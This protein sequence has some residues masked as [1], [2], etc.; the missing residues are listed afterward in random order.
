MFDLSSAGTCKTAM[1][2]HKDR[3]KKIPMFKLLSERMNPTLIPNLLPSD[4]IPEKCRNQI[5]N[6]IRMY[7]YPQFDHGFNDIC[8]KS[9][10][11]FIFVTGLD[12]D[13][14]DDLGALDYMLKT[15][16][17]ETFLDIL[18]ILCHTALS[19]A[20]FVAYYG[21][22]F[23]NDINDILKTNGIGYMLVGNLMVQFTE[24]T[25][26][27]EIVIP[28]L[29]SIL[30]LGFNTPSEHLTK[31]YESLKAGDN[32]NS[33]SEAYKGL[34]SLIELL[35]QK[36]SIKFDKNA[37]T[38]SKI[39]DLVK[40]FDLPPY[41]ESKINTLCELLKYPGEIRN[42]TAGHGSA[43]PVHVP[44]SLAKYEIDLVSSTILF[45]V[46]TYQSTQSP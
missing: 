36:R 43:N 37:K 3:L 14:P 46:R 7:Q 30:D 17:T 44:E 13:T 1:N 24:Q 42:A 22:D 26:A 28:A 20:E 8:Y 45:L 10:N 29:Q 34:E 4:E 18:D 32:E 15:S 16:D 40:S 11:A 21:N 12:P 39:N 25:E 2:V 27:E 33:I 41:M 23:K 9:I 5:R 35:L 19:D 31:A 6:I 38:S